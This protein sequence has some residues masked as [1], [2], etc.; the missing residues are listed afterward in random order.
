MDMSVKVVDIRIHRCRSN[1]HSHIASAGSPIIEEGPYGAY[2]IANRHPR[3]NQDVFLS[4]PV[5]T[6]Q[7]L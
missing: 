2:C 5:S 4:M 1:V 7:L 6:I 3:L